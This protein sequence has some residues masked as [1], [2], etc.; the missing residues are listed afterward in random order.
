M[1]PIRPFEARRR[2]LAGMGALAIA[3]RAGDGIAQPAASIDPTQPFSRPSSDLNLVLAVDCS[4]SVDAGVAAYAGDAPDLVLA[5]L[6][7]LLAGATPDAAAAAARGLRLGRHEAKRVT[8][9]VASL[10]RLP[11][12]GDQAGMRLFRAAMGSQLTLQL[13]LEAA[14]AE[15]EAEEGGGGG[16]ASGSVAA[17]RVDAFVDAWRALPPLA[18]PAS[19]AGCLLDGA[20]LMAATG[21]K[22]GK[23]L[24]RLKEW[25]WRV[26]VERDLASADEV[27]ALLDEL[28]WRESEPDGWPRMEW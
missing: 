11:D 24:G 2:F 22:P 3:G 15:A 17:Q 1:A 12:A 9:A 14:L 13:L 6:A 8:R 18:A 23:Q 25:L 4:R 16:A 28:P 26:Q 19:A 7:L 5:R 21:L 20:A 10:G 27:A